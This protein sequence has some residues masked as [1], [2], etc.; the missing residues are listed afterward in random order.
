MPYKLCENLLT[1][2]WA[3][4]IRKTWESAVKTEK[5]KVRMGVLLNTMTHVHKQP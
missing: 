5:M 2:F 3:Q 4:I 1:S